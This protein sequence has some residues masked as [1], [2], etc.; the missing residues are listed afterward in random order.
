MGFFCTCR[1]EWAQILRFMT[2][3]EELLEG[4][5]RHSYQLI[6]T[7][8]FNNSIIQI[9]A[10]ELQSNQSDTAILAFKDLATGDIVTNADF[11]AVTAVSDNEAVV[12]GSVDADGITPR[13]KAVAEGAANIV[14]SA[15]VK[16]TDNLGAA[17]AEP[18]QFKTPVTITAVATADGYELVVTWGTPFLS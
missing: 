17:R 14:V 13:A 3:I 9:M 6:L 12:I 2:R 16:W 10:L 4:K 8:L 18:F 7:K 5:K 1:E 15:I 11:S